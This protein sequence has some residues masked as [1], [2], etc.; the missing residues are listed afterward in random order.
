MLL[1]LQLRRRTRRKRPAGRERVRRAAYASCSPNRSAVR[2]ESE[3]PLGAFLSGGID[4]S[5]VVALM[6]RE[7][8]RPVKTFSIGFAEAELRRTAICARY[9]QC[10]RNRSS[11]I[12]RHPDVCGLAEEIIWHHDEPFADVSSIPTYIVSKMAK[13]HVTVVLSGD[14]GDEIFGGYERY[15]TD[16]AAA[17]SSS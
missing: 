2:L 8:G 17:R 7:M 5:A 1:E 3:V 16:R 10:A 15:V 4:S 6:A 11:R 13:E 9:R 14:G 12:R